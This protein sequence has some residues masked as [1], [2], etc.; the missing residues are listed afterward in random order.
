MTKT[1]V[2]ALEVQPNCHFTTGKWYE[3][4]DWWGDDEP[5]V[6]DDRGR[7]C[8]ILFWKS[9]YLDRDDWLRYDGDEAP[10]DGWRPGD[11]KPG[12]VTFHHP[13]LP[14]GEYVHEDG[15]KLI[16]TR[17]KETHE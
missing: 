6:R 3:V 7:L 8:A 2:M 15:T 14:E 4:A 1:F 16:I 5:V 11:Q 12:P 13:T 10:L 17:N 9:R